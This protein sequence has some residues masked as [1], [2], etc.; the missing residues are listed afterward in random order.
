LIQTNVEQNQQTNHN[1]D[2]VEINTNRIRFDFLGG[3]VQTEG[4]LSDSNI[5]DY[6]YDIDVIQNRLVSKKE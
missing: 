4:L 1:N 5:Q 2:I 3:K 6:G